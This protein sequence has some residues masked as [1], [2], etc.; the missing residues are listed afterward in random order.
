MT[1]RKASPALS[2]FTQFDD[3]CFGTES[4]NKSIPPKNEP[5]DLQAGLSGTGTVKPSASASSDLPFAFS[6]DKEDKE[7]ITCS[8]PTISHFTTA[9]VPSTIPKRRPPPELPLNLPA[10]KPVSHVVRLPFDN[11]STKSLAVELPTK[12]SVKVILPAGLY[13]LAELR[14]TLPV[15]SRS[16]YSDHR[17][18]E[19]LLS[20]RLLCECMSL[21]DHL[22]FYAGHLEEVAQSL[23]EALEDESDNIVRDLYRCITEIESSVPYN[24]IIIARTQNWAGCKFRPN[25]KAAIMSNK[26]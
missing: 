13:L 11:L 23:L 10:F 25:L 1:L 4:N 7:V 5:S 22:N 14:L 3:S 16:L 15:M 21:S 18:S 2:L 20:D 17:F 6:S 26:G 24:T 19:Q 9:K 8:E 12:S